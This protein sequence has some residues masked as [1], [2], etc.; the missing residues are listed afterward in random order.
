MTRI[1]PDL[2]LPPARHRT[3]RTPPEFLITAPASG[4][5]MMARQAGAAQN[6]SGD[7]GEKLSRAAGA[8]TRAAIIIPIVRRLLRL[9]PRPLHHRGPFDDFRLDERTEL[10]WR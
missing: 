6:R 3:L 4:R 9:Y 10:F 8:L 1:P 5:S 2:P 7:A